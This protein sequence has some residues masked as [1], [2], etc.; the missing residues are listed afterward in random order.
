[1]SWYEESTPMRRAPLQALDPGHSRRWARVCLAG[2][3]LLACAKHQA[4]PVEPAVPVKPPGPAN[5][6]ATEEGD[7]PGEWSLLHTSIG[8]FE[9]RMPEDIHTEQTAIRTAAGHAGV[10]FWKALHG[11]AMY[12]IRVTEYAGTRNLPDPQKVLDAER[13][14]TL[15][16]VDGIL[17]SEVPAVL[18]GYPARDLVVHIVNGGIAVELRI[19][20]ALID[21]RIFE[22]AAAVPHDRIPT[23]DLEQFF[24]SF[25]FLEPE[26]DPPPDPDVIRA[27]IRTHMDEFRR[28][29]NFASI[30]L[31]GLHGRLVMKFVIAP[32]G[33]LESHKAEP[34]DL[35]VELVRCM[36][37]VFGTLEF[38]QVKG[39]G[40]VLVTYPFVFEQ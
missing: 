30:G 15:E 14:R 29:N 24:A 32:S 8:N 10:F 3:L 7:D 2:A 23:A 6:P 33:A 21:D 4:P 18:A 9:V 31:P 17:G 16:S 38:P 28:C 36:L 19:R 12:A 27:I 20:I 13:T 5:P 25:R 26:P 37:E 1:M 34:S 35:P 39:G 40:K 22:L 11:E